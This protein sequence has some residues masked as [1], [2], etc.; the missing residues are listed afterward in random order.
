MKA[1]L[2]LLL[3]LL[4]LPVDLWAE[5]PMGGATAT[6]TPSGS[7]AAGPETCSGCGDQTAT[8]PPVPNPDP[9][10]QAN[11][12]NGS[13]DNQRGPSDAK[14]TPNPVQGTTPVPSPTLGAQSDLQAE[15]GVIVPGVISDF[16]PV[17]IKGESPLKSLNSR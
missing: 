15:P 4:A 10:P 12:S 11:G 9:V 6:A 3:F 7:G 16:K 13:T 2:I 1:V 5:E 8:V 17:S 14:A